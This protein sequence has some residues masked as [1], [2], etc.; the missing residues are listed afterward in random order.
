MKSFLPIFA[1]SLLMNG[2]TAQTQLLTPEKLWQL[3]RVGLEDVS[4]D[5]KT[6]VYGVTWYNL[7]ANKGTTDLYAIP[8]DGGEA[9]KITAYE[10]NKENARFR[11]D[12]KKIGY[13]RDGILWEMNP[14]G[15]DQRQVSDLEMNGFAY[16]PDGKHILLIRDVKYFKEVKDVYPDLPLATARIIDD[17]MYRHWKSWDDYQRSNVFYIGYED[18]KLLGEP[19]NIINEPFDSPLTP[20]GGME[21]ISW[22]ADSKYI[23]Y[24][25][26]KSNGKAEALTT[27]SD[28][29]LYELAS[30][31]TTN[32]SEGMK[33]YDL[34][35]VFSPNGQYVIWN[36]MEREGYEADRNRLFIYDLKSGK[37]EELTRSFDNDANNA[38]WS[39]DSK[40]IYFIGGDQG[41]VQLFALDVA[42]QKIRRIT[43]GVHD[44]TA[45]A[46]AGNRLVASRMSMSMPVE[47]YTINPLNGETKQ[48]TFTNKDL[49]A[50]LKTGEVKKR[51]VK[52][53]DGKQML[54]WMIYPPDFDKSKKY[55]TLLYCQG[56]PQSALSQY[57]SYRWNFQLMAANGYIVVAPCRRGMQSFGQAWNEEIS[58]DWGGQAM[59]DLL[60]AI[61]DA[62]KEPY[63]DANRLGAVGASFGGYSVYWLAGN[64]QK[65]FK[66][67]I[68]HCGMFNMES[69]YGT[70][71][72]MWF[73][74]WDFKGA[75][76]DNPET[77]K[78][79]SPHLFVKNW[80]TP[81]LVIHSEKDFRVPVSEGMQAF[82]AA[83]L[84]NI[85]S[86]FLYMENEGHWVSKPQNSVLWQREFYR[87]LDQYLK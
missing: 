3:G 60:S 67:F 82:Q 17:L 76:W 23:A 2:L 53:T 20:M 70:T 5:G 74:N 41:T 42:T 47:L 69:W 18:G 52:T 84:R 68:A 64:H 36:S 9:R 35:P 81:I 6:T 72:E 46:V 22:S 51:M 57:Y 44:Y 71:E 40:T 11:P 85:P 21:Q 80:D 4:P 15:S 27:N 10:G 55:P 31:K 14:D 87:F 34:E 61:D 37:R 86:R 26:K 50:T 19:V 32:L 65:R 79:F 58:G 78:K 39:A 59:Q 56:G 54:V 83:Q 75:Y 8:T 62:K 66:A 48:L 33:G 38:R 63:V 45:M 25:C 12:G 29:F 43:E 16:A 7:A 28:V 49:L 77:Y 30:G 73:A 13:L 24:S 1:L